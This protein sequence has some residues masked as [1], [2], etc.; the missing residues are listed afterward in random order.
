MW[1]KEG[2]KMDKERERQVTVVKEKREKDNGGT[3]EKNK[4]E[5]M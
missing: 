2:R 4:E 1:G 3:S 5:K